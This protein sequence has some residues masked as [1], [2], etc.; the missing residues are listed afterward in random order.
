ML[1][2]LWSK[3]FN[4]QQTECSLKPLNEYDAV[5]VLVKLSES[6]VEEI[7]DTEISQ[8]HPVQSFRPDLLPDTVETRVFRLM[9]NVL[10]TLGPLI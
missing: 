6:C 4:D 10:D 1:T 9:W 3:C 5:V 8:I 7:L 2:K